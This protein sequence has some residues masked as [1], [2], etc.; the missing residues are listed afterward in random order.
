MGCN[1]DAY[2]RLEAWTDASIEGKHAVA[3][4]ILKNDAREVVLSATI[5]LDRGKVSSNGAE[6]GAVLGL[7]QSVLVLGYHE[8]DLTVHSDSKLVVEQ[9]NDNWR[10]NNEKLREIRDKI[11]KL[12]ENFTGKVEF[13]W[14]PREENEEA[15][16]LSRSLYET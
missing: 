5:D 8:A 1:R 14:I 12:L 11:W 7:I 3:A 4:Y 15:D 13:V 16:E 9:L 2:M 10:C 6:Y